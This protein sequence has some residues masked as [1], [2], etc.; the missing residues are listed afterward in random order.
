MVLDLSK[1]G[2]EKEEFPIFTKQYPSPIKALVVEYMPEYPDWKL[3]NV[4]VYLEDGSWMMEQVA[5]MEPSE[6]VSV[7]NENDWFL[8]TSGFMQKLM[9]EE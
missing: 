8:M 6:A 1:L 9:K 3:V 2:K 4:S 5:I 7:A